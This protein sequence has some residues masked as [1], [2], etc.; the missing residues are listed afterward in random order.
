MPLRPEVA[1]VY[2]ASLRVCC[3]PCVAERMN[4]RRRGKAGGGEEGVVC[5]GAWEAMEDVRGEEEA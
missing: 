1:Q 4:G 2:G 3:T 5:L